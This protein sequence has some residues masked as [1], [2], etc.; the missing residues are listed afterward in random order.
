MFTE[1]SFAVFTIDGLEPR[2]AAIRAE[3]QPVFHSLQAEFQP[4]IEERIQ[5]ELFLHIAQHRRRSVYPPESTL[6]ALSQKKRGYK[7]E[8]H[9]QLGICEEYVFMWLSLIDQPPQKSEMAEKMLT[10]HELFEELPKDSILSPNHMENAVLPLESTTLEKTLRRLR[11]V[12]KGE[13]QVGR[14]LLKDSE[15]WQHPEEAKAYM[16]ESY[17]ALVPLYNLLMQV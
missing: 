2:M 8:P 1:K 6:S 11:D 5:K 12:K 16:L 17:L 14:V 4:I 10:H 15:L 13:F 9:F 3:I 7:M